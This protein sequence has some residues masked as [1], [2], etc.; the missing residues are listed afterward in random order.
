MTM[1]T[2]RA[3]SIPLRLKNVMNPEGTGT[4][5]YASRVSPSETPNRSPDHSDNL[6][7]HFSSSH[8]EGKGAPTRFFMTT[9]GYYGE[10]HERRVPTAL[11]AKDSITVVTVKSTRGI[12][13]HVF[14]G[15]ISQILGSHDLS[16]DLISSSIN[17][18]SF[19]VST[20]SPRTN[21]IEEVLEELKDIGTTTVNG[22]M[23]IVSVV[24]HKMRNMVGVAGT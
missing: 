16:I 12:K 22:N 4:I 9:N 19:A 1:D 7:F 10:A 20:S 3:F 8:V 15:Q 21:L 2:I 11:T 5:I 24:G 13:S 14:L 23:S 17:S 6:N 18:V